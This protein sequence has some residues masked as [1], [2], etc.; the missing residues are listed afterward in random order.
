MISVES[1]VTR[2]EKLSQFLIYFQQG[3]TNWTPSIF[4]I[5]YDNGYKV[6]NPLKSF[7]KCHYLLTLQVLYFQLLRFTERRMKRNTSISIISLILAILHLFQRHLVIK[8]KSS[9]TPLGMFPGATKSKEWV[10]I[11]SCLGRKGNETKRHNGAPLRWNRNHL[12]H[13]SWCRKLLKRQWL[14]WVCAL[15]LFS[16]LSNEIK[17]GSSFSLDVWEE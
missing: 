2:C 14:S 6:H 10:I 3:L 4:G 16:H 17:T 9:L 13:T 7:R 15:P 12:H 11:V 5:Q 8:G 1:Q